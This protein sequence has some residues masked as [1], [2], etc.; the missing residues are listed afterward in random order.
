MIFKQGYY[1]LLIFGY[2]AL[3]ATQGYGFNLDGDKWPAASTTF[4][5]GIP[6]VGG[7]PNWDDAFEQ[8]AVKW[9]FA[10]V[11]TFTIVKGSVVDPCQNPNEVTPKN[12][13]KFASTFCGV[14][15]GSQVLA[16]EQSWVIDGT[17]IQ[18][19]IVFNSNES[20]DV[21][22]SAHST[23]PKE[24]IKDFRRIA[25]HE[26]GHSLGLGHEDDLPSIMDTL[27]PVGSLEISPQADDINAVATL[28]DGD[29]DGVV[30]N[31]DAFPLD[32]NE[33]ADTDND[34]IGDNYE[35]A[36]GLNPQDAADA[37]LDPDSDGLT[38]LKEF[39]SGRNPTVNENAIIMIINSILLEE[40][41]TDKDGVPDSQDAFP[42][43]ANESVDTDN[44]GTGNNADT[45][46][47]ND[48]VA[49]S[50]DAFPLNANESADTDNDGIG[51][52][53][54]NCSTI[55]NTDQQ[56]TDSDGTGN[57]CDTD[58]DND[59]VVDNS[60]NCPLISNTNQQDTDTDGTGDVCDSD[61]DND[62]VADSSDAFPLNANESA[63]TDNDG[64]GD[65]SDNCPTISNINQQD[66]DLDGT[67]DVCD[68]DNDNDGVVDN[69][70]AFPLNAN[71]SV[72][73]DN[74]GI[75]NNYE[76][77]H[78]LNPE[79]AADADLD[80][81]S[82]GLTNLEEFLLGRDA[83]VDETAVLPIINSILG[84]ED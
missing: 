6:V 30:D 66:I 43:D 76:T 65:N 5:V 28:Y 24:N 34:G 69:S 32:P 73:T 61:D 19:G 14:P 33:S 83:T 4:H 55:S 22:D 78:G 62:G 26:L 23:T 59:T 49:D 46:D 60:D 20:W 58:D 77:A 42:E 57:V 56:D 10:T 67:G 21:Y 52:N 54:D 81:D 11:F 16:L 25:V 17:I 47:D 75:G 8:A 3:F 82:D 50:S 29:F 51:D 15:W 79:N 53:S 27:L 36:H 70:D 1:S 2:F 80:P 84:I 48:G 71:E 37:D 41:D 40:N 9:N 39:Q 45:D 68:A 7:D 35:T 74:D 38:N 44:D 63:D 31:L 18:S 12:G 64:I 72:D 13:V